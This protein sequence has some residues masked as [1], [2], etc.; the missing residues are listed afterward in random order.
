MGEIVGYESAFDIWEALR[1]VYES[2]SIAPIMGFCSQ[3]Q[4]IKKDG[5]TVSQYLAQIKDV[6]DNFAAIGEPLSYRDHLSYILEGLGS[7]YN[8]FVSSIHNRTNRPSIADVRN[9][10]ITYDSRLEKQTA[11]D[12]LQLIQANVAH[13][14]INSQNR[15]PQWQQHNRSSIRSSTPS[16]GSFPSILPN[17][18]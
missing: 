13:L 8:P 4:K 3:L 10:L 6:L 12:H 9:L 17:P 15:H 7:E 2:S 1:T 5:L 14:S 18:L 11:T 16:V